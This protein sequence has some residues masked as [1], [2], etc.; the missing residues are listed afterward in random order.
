MSFETCTCRVGRGV[1]IAARVYH[2]AVASSPLLIS[3][4]FGMTKEDSH[5]LADNLCAVHG[6]TVVTMDNRGSGDSDNPPFGDR[7]G[8]QCMAQDC[9]GLMRALGFGRYALDLSLNL[10]K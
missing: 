9:V 6:F 10:L 5:A 4:G 8:M 3:R 7:P 1:R 2:G